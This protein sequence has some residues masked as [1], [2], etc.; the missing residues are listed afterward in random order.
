MVKE[1]Q[2]FPNNLIRIGQNAK[3]ND[4]LVKNSKETDIWFH[5]SGLPS[6]HVIIEVSKDFPITKQMIYYC[7]NLVKENTKYKNVPKI[8]INYTEIKNV[9]RTNVPGKVI[10]KGKINSVT[11]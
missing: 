10:I 1:D 9:S 11:I 2:I 7:A 5:I 6:C 4:E 8:K 3:E